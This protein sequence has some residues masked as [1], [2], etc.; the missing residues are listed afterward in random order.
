MKIADSAPAPSRESHPLSLTPAQFTRLV[1]S[2]KIVDGRA[3]G[4]VFG[5]SYAEG[6]IWLVRKLGGTYLLEGLVEGGV[7][8]VN[9]KAATRNLSRLKA[10]NAGL[11][12]AEARPADGQP[13]PLSQVIITS[14][15]P[16]DRMIYAHW[17]QVVVSREA[18]VK[19]IEELAA[20]NEAPN[21]Y[22]NCDLSQILDQGGT[23]DGVV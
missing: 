1:L 7:F 8:L 13:P 2:G 4:L 21:P 22:L 17:A 19:H 18:A 6:G 23:A 5:R 11:A 9:W 14:A 3:G 15:N 20:M 12:K 10:M 16:D